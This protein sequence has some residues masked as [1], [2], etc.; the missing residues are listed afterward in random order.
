VKFVSILKLDPKSAAK[1]PS[2]K[3]FAAMG[4]LIGEMQ[5]AGV[6][7]DTGGVLPGSTSLRVRREDGAVTVTDGPF[8]E[9]KEVVG[10]FAVFDVQS[11]D[12]VIAWTRRFL[13]CAGDGVTEIHEVTGAP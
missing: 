6:L 3:N 10:G 9:T 5:A 4:Q 7:V 13:D 8:A 12:E 2:E 1:P 11:K